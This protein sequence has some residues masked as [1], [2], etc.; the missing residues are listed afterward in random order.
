MK[1]YFEFI[2]CQFKLLFISLPVGFFA[3]CGYA[4]Y[5]DKPIM[6]DKLLITLLVFGLGMPLLG[7]VYR[8]KS[9]KTF[10]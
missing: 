5:A 7:C 3:H 8:I 6:W 1:K 10:L 4:W 2:L 9:V